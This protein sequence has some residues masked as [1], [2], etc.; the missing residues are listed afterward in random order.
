MLCLV[1]TK[2]ALAATWEELF[3]S[4]SGNEEAKVEMKQYSFK[5]RLT[6]GEKIINAH[7]KMFYKKDGTTMEATSDYEVYC[8]ARKVFRSNLKMK[9]KETN[10]TEN[11]VS[12][13]SKMTL[14]GKEYKDFIGLMDILCSK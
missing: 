1:T 9:V 11:T 4:K 6:Q 2:T 10:G 3:H 8:A 14:E 12:V 13:P 5:K 7:L